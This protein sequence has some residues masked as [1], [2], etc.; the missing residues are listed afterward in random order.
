[1]GFKVKFKEIIIEI[2]YLLIIAF[3]VS[4]ISREAM[5]YLDNYYI[6]LL[7]AMYHEL[8][9]ILVATL[10]NKKLRKVFISICGMTAYF[11]YQ[12][13]NKNRLYYIKD[14]FIFIAGPVANLIMALMFKENKFVFE[15]NL[16]LA[17]LNLLPIY[18]LDGF[19]A[20]QSLLRSISMNNN[21]KIN[22]IVKYMS[23]VFLLFLSM[24]CIIVLYKYENISS[25][26]FLVY[27]LFLNIRK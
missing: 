24:L 16:F 1:M 9:H 25:M 15:I 19:N 27:I 3:L 14:F 10:L 6:C 26:I 5:N 7:F 2:E 21:A 20:I 11:K 22:E 18:P 23:I 8:A 13:M 4:I 12:Y 17:L